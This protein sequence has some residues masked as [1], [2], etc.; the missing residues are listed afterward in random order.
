MGSMRGEWKTSAWSSQASSQACKASH[1]I[2]FGMLNGTEWQYHCSSDGP[3]DS[4]GRTWKERIFHLCSVFF[5]FSCRLAATEF[6]WTAILINVGKRRKET[7]KTFIV[8]RDQPPSL[9]SKAVRYG[10]CQGCVERKLIKAAFPSV[11]PSPPCLSGWASHRPPPQSQTPSAAQEK[12]ITVVFW[13]RSMT[14]KS[15]SIKKVH[16]QSFTVVCF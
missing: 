10:A 9:F 5:S 15:A 12:F 14:G 11:L 1:G 16:L 3:T 4:L 7:P 2:L 8:L 13:A 6:N